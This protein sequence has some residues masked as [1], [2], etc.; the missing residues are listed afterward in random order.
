[1]FSQ[2]MAIK[3]LELQR[4]L[5]QTFGVLMRATEKLHLMKMSWNVSFLI[6][7]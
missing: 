2:D 7:L 3:M 5:P 1:M 4:P 6:A